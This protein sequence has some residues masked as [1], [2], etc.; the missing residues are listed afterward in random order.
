[1]NS[2]GRFESTN[3]Y[4]TPVLTSIYGV[5]SSNTLILISTALG[6]SNMAELS[7]FLDVTTEHLYLSIKLHV[8]THQVRCC[9]KSLTVIRRY[10]MRYILCVRIDSYCRLIHYRLKDTKLCVLAPLRRNFWFGRLFPRLVVINTQGSWYGISMS[11]YLQD[12]FW[13]LIFLCVR[14]NS[15]YFSSFTLPGEHTL[16]MSASD[17]V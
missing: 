15:N 9:S 10:V 16:C 11:W 3:H 4:C 5:V 12:L 6:I 1:V 13:N 14:Q 8:V 2:Y 17:T 7:V